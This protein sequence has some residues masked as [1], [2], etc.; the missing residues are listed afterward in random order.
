[1][2]ADQAIRHIP[3][4][5]CS[6]R[7][8]EVSNVKRDE[9]LFRL[10]N[11]ALRLAVKPQPLK[12]DLSTELRVAQALSRRGLALEMA[13]V[14]SFQVHEEYSRSL[15][16]HLHRPPPPKF[17]PPRID[18]LLRADREMWIRVSEQV[19]SDFTGPGKSGV[20][21]SAIQTWQHSMQ[22]AY[23]LVPVPKPG[24]P[25]RLP[26]KRFLGAVLQR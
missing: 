14:A 5:R 15:L 20:V 24:K 2:M 10:E 18:S 9:N 21:D 1:M 4:N 8:Q 25:D 13:G 12:V 26:G 16:E 11:A 7:E 22:V 19:K 6:S 17:D 23:F 3:L